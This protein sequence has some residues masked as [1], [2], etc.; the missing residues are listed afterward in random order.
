MGWVLPW[1]RW[2][3]TTTLVLFDPPLVLGAFVWGNVLLL[4]WLGFAAV[5]LLA[6]TL[7]QAVGQ[8]AGLALAGRCCCCWRA[9]CRWWGL[10]P[11]GLV[12]WASQLGLGRR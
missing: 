11:A 9:R 10:C 7:A 1:R 12:A 6:N 2:G 4:T 3:P 8:A 5:T